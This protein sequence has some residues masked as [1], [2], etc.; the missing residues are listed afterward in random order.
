[1]PEL[2][3]LA[4]FG[5]RRS[6]D[7]PSIHRARADVYAVRVVLRLSAR[8]R[9]R[10]LGAVDGG[11][12]DVI[13]A[14]VD[15]STTVRARL[16]L[17]RAEVLGDRIAEH[18]LIDWVGGVVRHRDQQT[19]VSRTELRILAVLLERRGR[20]I[21][22]VELANAVWGESAGCASASRAISV[23]V[24]SL[25]KRLRSIGLG[26]AVETVRGSGYRVVVGAR[27]R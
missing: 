2:H 5:P 9:Q 21:S 1:M 11:G 26:G 13:I 12:A 23:Y 3:E 10:L 25:R 6:E 4:P 15:G 8:A 16:S 17:Q 19:R 27:T 18:V 22:R 14:S 7:I 20:T 24:C